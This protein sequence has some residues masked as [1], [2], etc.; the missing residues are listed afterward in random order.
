MREHSYQTFLEWT[1]NRGEGTKSYRTYDRAY[2]IYR[3]EVAEKPII[4]S[5]SDPAF[6]GNRSKYNSEE[7]LVA[8]LSSCH[9]LWYL[10]LCVKA[11]VIVVEYVDLASGKISK[12]ED[13]SGKFV[14]VT[15]Q[16]DITISSDSDPEIAKQLH[17][18]AHQF[19]FIANSVNFPVRCQPSIKH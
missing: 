9:L 19:C 5:S 2:M 3:I 18:K 4:M 17:E 11:G 13:G 14:E 15:L 8:S 10:H 1:G 12:N 16:P 7:L 6:L